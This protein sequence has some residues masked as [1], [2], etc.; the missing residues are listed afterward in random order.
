MEQK[1]AQ[2]LAQIAY[3]QVELAD[4]YALIREQAGQCECALELKLADRLTIYRAEKPNV[5]YDFAMLMLVGENKEAAQIFKQFRELT[6]KYKGLEK[7]IEARQ[8]IISYEQSKMK[9]VLQ[10]ERYA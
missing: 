2:E 3:K 5:G 4:E 8:S 9:Y 7:Q 6:G 1:Q 10:G